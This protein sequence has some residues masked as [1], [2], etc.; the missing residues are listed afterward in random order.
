ME[1]LKGLWISR[2]FTG[3]GILVVK[4]TGPLPKVINHGGKLYAEN[5]QFYTGVRIEIGKTGKVSVANGTYI[6]RNTLII[7]EKEV[8]IGAN[9][10]I[11]WDV[12]I[13]DSDMHPLNSFTVQHKSVHIED[14]VWIGCRCII[15]KGVTIGKGAIIAAGSVV[16]KDVPEMK[17]YGGV[18]AKYIT[19][20]KP[21]S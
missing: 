21:Y 4:D 14:N 16:T 20:V 6:N 12:I 9:C 10:K 15:L 7:S 1:H 13:M 19:D 5:C 18:P 17:I 2:K 8:N 3:H 11:S